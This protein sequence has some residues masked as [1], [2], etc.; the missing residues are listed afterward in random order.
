MPSRFSNV[1]WSDLRLCGT[2]APMISTEGWRRLYKVCDPK[3]R[4]HIDELGLF[5]ERSDSVA[6]KIANSLNAGFDECSGLP[7]RVMPAMNLLGDW[8]ACGNRTRY[9]SS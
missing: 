6:R 4:L 9:R 5:V 2:V 7:S 1:T 8:R 3:E